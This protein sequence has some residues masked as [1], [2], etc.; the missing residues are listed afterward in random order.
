MSRNVFESGQITVRDLPEVIKF[1][2]RHGRAVLILGPMGCGKSQVVKQ[3]ADSIYGE[4]DD[5]LVDIRLS[6]KDPTDLSGLP[7][8]VQGDG[9]ETRTVFAVPDFW[10]NDPDWEGI[11]FLDEL[12]HADN[13]LQKVAMQIM[14]DH[15]CGTYTFPK[16]SVFVGA[17]NRSTDG[18]VLSALEAPLAN[19]FVIVEVVSNAEVFIEDFAFLNGVHSSVI[20]YLKKVPSSIDNYE[21]MADIGCP[22]FATPRS[23]EVASDILTDFDA[24]II[25][26]SLARVFL[27]GA[28]GHTMAIEIWTYHTKKRNLPEI[29]QIM[30][31]K[32]KEYNGPK[33]PDILWIL[34]S[35]GCIAIRNMMENASVGDEE[36][37][38]CVANFLDFL[39]ENFRD[40]NRDFVFSVF[41]AMMKPN[42]LGNALLVGKGRDKI[43]AQLI[44]AYPNLMKIV[45][46]FGEEFSAILAKA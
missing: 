34:G 22:S 12:T 19:R 42:A 46:E 37:V 2:K 24:G 41:M 40:E 4:R 16:G 23:W 8:P 32:Y 25:T 36:L 29:G 27:Q 20:G 21:A 15:K 6:D 39:W 44:K 5:N 3:T 13:Y 26:E 31:G 11:I 9:G 14:L 10:P 30:A 45:K 18:A 1:A 33:Q 35:E 7:I 17:G 38:S 43:M 28:I